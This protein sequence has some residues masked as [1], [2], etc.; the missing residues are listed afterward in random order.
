MRDR[1]MGRRLGHA[2][3]LG[4]GEDNVKVPQP[5][6]AADPICPVHPRP[7]SQEA[8]GYLEESF[9]TTVSARTIATAI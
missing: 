4:H 1:Q 7:L 3:A 9:Q 5:D 2:A 8:K 6:A